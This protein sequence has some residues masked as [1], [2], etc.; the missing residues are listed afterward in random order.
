IKQCTRHN[1]IA[2]SNI[3]AHF[4]VSHSEPKRVLSS[5][6][7]V[8]AVYEHPSE[9]SLR[10]AESLWDTASWYCDNMQL[11]YSHDPVIA[12]VATKKADRMKQDQRE[13]ERKEYM[14]VEHEKVRD[15][16]RKRNATTK[17]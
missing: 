15:V 9:A 10:E 1:Y 11:Q 7:I 3:H 12:L 17:K 16:I 13:K 14:E 4:I 2:G 8:L 5:Q 6:H